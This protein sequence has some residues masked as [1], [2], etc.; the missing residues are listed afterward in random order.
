MSI[1]QTFINWYKKDGVK[2]IL[3]NINWLVLDR[4]LRMVGGLLINAWVS[5][6]LG[7]TKMGI[8]DISVSVASLFLIFSSFGLDR[9]AIR[10]FVNSDRDTTNSNLSVLFSIRSIT[11][12]IAFLASGAV[13]QYIAD[14]SQ[15]R[16]IVG[17]MIS[18][19]ILVQVFDIL[20]FKLQA[21][22]LSK[23]TVIAKGIGFIISSLLKIICITESLS[24]EYF[25][26]TYLID[27][28]FGF[29]I[30][31]IIFIRKYP[32]L[33]FKFS[34]TV[35]KDYWTTF[36]PLLL[37]SL[38]FIIYSKIDQ[39]MIDRMIDETAVG[40]YTRAVKLNDIAIAIYTIMASSLFPELTKQFNKGI[41]DL[42]KSYER[43][44][45][46]LSGLSYIGVIATILLSDFVIEILYGASYAGAADNLKILIIGMIFLYN[47]GMKGNYL[48]LLNKKKIITITSFASIFINIGMNALLIPKFGANGAAM[49]SVVTLCFVNFLINF[50]FK[51]TRIVGKIQFRSFF[52]VHFIKKYIL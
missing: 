25:V 49:A 13:L 18:S 5:R 52:L 4:I 6:Y 30:L 8:W 23:Y 29:L 3:Q 12:L 37:S 41:K 44:C 27:F 14:G 50:L 16:I 51:D 24:L 38:A 20:T 34:K 15:E 19:S 22:L 32:D 46:M 45:S 47:G 1:K 11:A 17:W 10:N 35:F 9:L 28:I 21:D 43:I 42:N 31:S 39:I 36:L 26:A 33:E 48:I 40:V 2:S 7:P